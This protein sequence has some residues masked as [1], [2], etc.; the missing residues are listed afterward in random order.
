MTVTPLPLKAPEE[1]DRYTD[2]ASGLRYLWRIGPVIPG[3]DSLGLG[4]IREDLL[5]RA[6]SS[7]AQ[8]KAAG[9]AGNFTLETICQTTARVCRE[10]AAQVVTYALTPTW[11]VVPAWGTEA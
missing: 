5:A 8:G 6:A 9:E 3:L 1:P 4:H 10:T 11:A 7:E 2:H